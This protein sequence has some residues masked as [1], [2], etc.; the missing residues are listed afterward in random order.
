[1]ERVAG[2]P[3]SRG[4]FARSWTRSRRTKMPCVLTRGSKPRACL[5]AYE[6][7]ARIKGCTE[8]AVLARFDEFLARMAERNVDAA[9]TRSRQTSKPRSQRCG[10]M[11]AV[12]DTSVLIRAL[13]NP[14][15]TVGPLVW[16]L[17][18]GDY[19]LLYLGGLPGR[20]SRHHEQASASGS[21]LA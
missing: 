10:L 14:T 12:V 11:R 5:I 18:R 4:A 20:A 17:R 13:M 3:S 2:R 6:D 21:S 1:M 19:T 7:Y 9:T 15:G 8:R 16:K